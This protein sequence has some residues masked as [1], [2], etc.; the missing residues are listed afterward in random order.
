[1]SFVK[2]RTAAIEYEGTH[3]TTHMT[4]AGTMLMSVKRNSF[5]RMQLGHATTI[6]CLTEI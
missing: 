5:L 1:V 6:A 3:S 2:V 4:L